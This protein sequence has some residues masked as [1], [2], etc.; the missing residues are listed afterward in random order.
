[1]LRGL[2][3]RKASAK[4][5]IQASLRTERTEREKRYYVA[6]MAELGTGIHL[7][8]AGIKGEEDACLPSTVATYSCPRYCIIPNT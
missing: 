3:P 4:A 5:Q 6:V 8:I 1:M 2:T 7:C